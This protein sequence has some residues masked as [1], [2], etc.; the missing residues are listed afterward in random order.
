VITGAGG[1]HPDLI[2][3]YLQM[4]SDGSAENIGY[5]ENGQGNMQGTPW[6]Q[7]ER[8]LQNS[9]VFLLDHVET[10]LLIGVGE[11]DSRLIGTDAIF[12]GLQRLGKSVEYR[13]YE[14]ESHV[15]RSPPNIVDFWNRRLEFLEQNLA[16]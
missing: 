8:Y 5:Y 11:Q 14:N 2:A 1:L 12:L 6:T 16:H 4:T 15:L 10:P 13:I 7:R 3:G 9:P